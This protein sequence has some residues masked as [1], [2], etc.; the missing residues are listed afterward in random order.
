MKWI[1]SNSRPW[2]Q[3]LSGNTL[4]R[5]LKGGIDPLPPGG[6]C[7]ITYNFNSH[8][9]HFLPTFAI[10]TCSTVVEFTHVFA[11]SILVILEYK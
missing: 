8:M 1:I 2:P 7:N 9:L 10:N 11:Q 3:N 5:P 6:I 4:I